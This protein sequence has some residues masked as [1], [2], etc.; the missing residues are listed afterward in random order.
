MVAKEIV[1]EGAQWNIGN[2]SKVRIWEDKWMPTPTHF[3][4]ISPRK[5][6]QEGNQ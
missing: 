3:K 6:I 1:V 4:P 2:G 5:N